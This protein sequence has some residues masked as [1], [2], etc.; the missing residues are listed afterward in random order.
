EDA[1]TT[2]ETT[3]ETLA[4]ARPAADDGGDEPS[5]SPWPV[6]LAAAAILAALGAFLLLQLR[7]AGR[8]DDEDDDESDRLDGRALDEAFGPCVTE[9]LELERAQAA[10]ASAGVQIESLRRRDEEGAGLVALARMRLAEARA[11]R[12]SL[13]AERPDEPHPIHLAAETLTTD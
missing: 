1:A 5:G 9:E 12:E 6:V 11:A 2:V 10:L 13:R 3:A 4:V 7:R 8:A